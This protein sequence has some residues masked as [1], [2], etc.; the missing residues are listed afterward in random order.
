MVPL[1]SIDEDAEPLRDSL[2]YMRNL[3]LGGVPHLQEEAGPGVPHL[4]L[5]ESYQQLSD[6]VFCAALASMHGCTSFWK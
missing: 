3:G 2:V 5:Q 4:V 1:N 6:A